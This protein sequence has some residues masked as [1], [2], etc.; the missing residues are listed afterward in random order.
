MK[1]APLVIKNK[2]TMVAMAAGRTI[3][4]F[5]RNLSLMLQPCVLTAA[6]VVSEIIERLSPNMAPETTAPMQTAIGKF[7]FWLIPMAIGASAAIVPMEVPIDI[8]MKHPMTKSPITAMPGGKRERPR[9]TVLFTPPAAETLPEKAPATRKIRHIVMMLSS[10][11]PLAII[12][13]FSLKLM[14]LVCKKATASAIKNPMT[15]GIE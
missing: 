4:K 12:E 13:I 9:L 5:L 6:M 10:P 8:E 7:V 3:K 2:I 1:F 11:T 15:A 14:P